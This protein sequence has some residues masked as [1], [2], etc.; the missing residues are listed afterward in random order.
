MTLSVSDVDD[1]LCSFEINEIF[2]SYPELHEDFLEEGAGLG[3]ALNDEKRQQKEEDKA[4]LRDLDA[5]TE[6]HCEEKLV[7]EEGGFSEST[8]EYTTEEEERIS[9]TSDLCVLAEVRQDTGRKMSSL[10]QNEQ[11]ISKCVLNLKIFQSMLQQAADSLCRTEEKLDKLEATEKQKKL[12]Q[13][14]GMNQLSKQICQE[15]H[16][17]RSDDTFQNTN[18]PFS[19]VNTFLW[20]AIGPPSSDYIPPLITHQAQG[21]L[22]GDS[23]QAVSKTAKEMQ[24]IQNEKWKCFYEMSKGKNENNLHDLGFSVVKSLDDEMS[25]DREV[26]CW[27]GWL[28]LSLLYSLAAKE[29]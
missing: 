26:K 9:E 14:I 10:S 17:N 29:M 25:L 1:S 15:R 13:E 28:C 24:A 22:G 5:S 27:A 4:T 3:Q 18:N 16:W 2:A 20:K 23:F 21:V 19:E 12:L 8:T 6:V 11:H 7:Y